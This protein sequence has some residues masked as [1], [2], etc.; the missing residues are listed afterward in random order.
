MKRQR[1]DCD[2]L[3]VGSGPGGATTA[4][5]L[6]EAGHDVLLVEEGR[7]LSLDSAVPYSLDEIDQKYR[8]GGLTP[9]FGKTNVTYIEGRCVG[10]GS[11]INAALCHP[12]MPETLEQW[13]VIYQIDEFG[14]KALAPYLEDV[15]R[16]LTVSFLPYELG[17]ASRKIKEGADAMGWKSEEVARFWHYPE[18]CDSHEK[19]SRQSMTATMVPRALA[20]GCRLRSRTRVRRLGLKGHRAVF[21]DAVSRGPDGTRQALRIHFEQVFVCGGPIQTPTILRRSGLKGK[22]GKG[23]TMHPMLRMPVRFDEEVNDPSYGVPVQQVVEFKPQLTLGCSNASLPHLVMWLGGQ[24][25]DRERKLAEWRKMALFYVLVMG[26]RRGFVRSLPGTEEAFAYYPIN[27]EDLALLVEG[28]YRLG[29][30]LF[31]VGAKEIFSPVAGAASITDERDLG[32]LRTG[33]P[34]GKM[35]ISTIHLFAT[36]PMGGDPRRAVVDS[37]GKMLDM[38]NIWINDA[39]ILPAGTGVNPQAT[40][41][42]VARRNVARWLAARG[43]R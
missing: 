29:K 16:D 32:I 3:V 6:A 37:F 8:N 20:A 15:F 22:V 39:S 17:P 35:S 10:G 9:S 34:Q 14:E 21:A 30:M 1:L 43:S 11:E 13:K 19:G 4:C 26:T 25:Q 24:V 7:N 38:D 41:M 12:P 31:A 36:C 42:A 2:V 5:L 40:L 27:D 18:K 23:L 28:L 33:L